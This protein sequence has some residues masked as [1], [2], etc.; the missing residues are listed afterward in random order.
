MRKWLATILI[1]LASLRLIAPALRGWGAAE[2]LFHEASHVLVFPL[3]DDFTAELRTQRKASPHL[4]HVALFYLT[5]EVV[6]EALAERAITYEPY[7]YKTGLLDRMWP[8]LRGPIETHWKPFVDGQ[9]ERD[10]AVRNVVGAVDGSEMSVAAFF[11]DIVFRWRAVEV[12][13]LFVLALRALL[14]IAVIT[15]FLALTVRTLTHPAGN[16]VLH[17]LATGFTL[18]AARGLVGIVK[19]RSRTVR[20]AVAVVAA[21][22][23]YVSARGLALVA[24]WALAGRATG[25]RGGSNFSGV[26]HPCLEPRAR[27]ARLDRIAQS[28]SMPAQAR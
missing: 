14:V 23:I 20:V 8:D 19:T 5:G 4:W 24:V 25:R 21:P 11:T 3:M 9:V 26:G 6:R 16:V 7:L 22:L 18:I 17:A 2:V 28:A 13:A 1:V 12:A 27:R 15:A 10:D